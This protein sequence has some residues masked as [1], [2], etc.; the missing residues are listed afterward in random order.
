MVVLP[1]FPL[2][3]VFVSFLSYRSFLSFVPFVM[4]FLCFRSLHRARS[5]PAP[6]FP[7]HSH[8]CSGSGCVFVP[9]L[10]S[11]R[12]RLPCLLLSLSTRHP[13]FLYPRYPLALHPYP[14][15]STSVLPLSSSIFLFFASLTFRPLVANLPLALALLPCSFTR[16]FNPPP[17]FPCCFASFHALFTFSSA[18]LT[19]LAFVLVLSLSFVSISLA[20]S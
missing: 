13:H 6:V 7:R 10:R 4:F 5:C 18:I 1:P 11:P 17:L 2:F 8:L 19:V 20:P 3:L 15:P 9:S 14:R 16:P 12:P